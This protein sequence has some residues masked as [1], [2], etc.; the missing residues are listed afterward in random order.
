VIELGPTNATIHQIDE[1]LPV[2]D[3]ERLSRIYQDIL[4][5]L[6]A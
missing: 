4:Q 3:L 1:R 6:L 2:A 5:R